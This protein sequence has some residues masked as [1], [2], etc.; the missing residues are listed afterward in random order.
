MPVESLKSC[1]WGYKF[2]AKVFILEYEILTGRLNNYEFNPTT[3]VR[4][5]K[6][7]FALVDLGLVR[8][9]ILLFG[10][11]IPIVYMLKGVHFGT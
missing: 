7:R 5:G 10:G 8:G 4:M 2:F 1:T 3:L 11:I 9:S 6:V